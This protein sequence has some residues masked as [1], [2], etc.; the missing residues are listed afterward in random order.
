MSDDVLKDIDSLFEIDFD[1][2]IFEIE[3]EPLEID[4]EP[5]EFELDDND[6]WQVEAR[7]KREKN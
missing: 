1:D 6:E 4:F 2:D 7:A 3:F 5:F